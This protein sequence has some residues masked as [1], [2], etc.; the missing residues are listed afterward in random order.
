MNSSSSESSPEVQA[1]GELRSNHQPESETL[2][3]LTDATI[4][5]VREGVAAAS[6]RSIR[7]TIETTLNQLSAISQE[8]TEPRVNANIRRWVVRSLIHALFSIHVE[9]IENIP[10]TPAILAANHLHHI[11]PLV[12]LAEIPTQP[13]YYILGDAR[14][15]YNKCWKRF[16]LGFAGGVIPLERI[17]GEELAVMAAAKAGQEEVKELA[18]AIQEN[19]N[20]GGDI[21][22]LRRIDRIVA[23]IFNRGD[24]LIL[25]PEGR[26]GTAEGHLHPF[27]RG[28][29]IYALRAGLP[30]IP[31]A[32]IGTHDLFLR[33]ELMIRVGEP[34]YFPPTTRPKRQEIDAAL[35][36]LEKAI[37]ALLPTNYQ[38]PTGIKLLRHF[39]NR[40]LW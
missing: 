39:L 23:A 16:I 31:I 11:D 24:G 15:L 1:D 3:L 9:N 21:Q 6:D 33:K 22:T 20:P 28:T 40:M 18:T 25:F 35:E 38:E 34:L 7:H 8:Y 37:Q 26:L 13:H 4:K 14:T 5:R 30:I 27:K 36:A 19:V 17:W 32:L 29:V 12:L 2:P 10:P